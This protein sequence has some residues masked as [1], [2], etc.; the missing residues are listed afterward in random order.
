[1]PPKPAGGQSEGPKFLKFKV[2][3]GVAPKLAAI[4]PKLSPLGVNPNKV[5]TDMA[6]ASK[7]FKGFKVI[8]ELKVENRNAEIKL[9]PT[10]SPLILKALGEDPRDREKV[11]N[12][13][14]NG[15]LSIDQIKDIAEIIKTKSKAKDLKGTMK[16]VL[17]TCL[18]IGCTV[19]GKNPKLIQAALEKGEYKI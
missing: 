13:K 19:E 1:M 12:V 18:T 7:D 15:N 3:G 8:I 11:K 5:A 9:I 10:C 6:A 16:E 17:G 14:H 2:I 4:A